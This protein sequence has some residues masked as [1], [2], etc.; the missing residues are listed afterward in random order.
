MNLYISLVNSNGKEFP[1][2]NCSFFK[3]EDS[4]I[5]KDLI[6]ISGGGDVV[7]YNVYSELG[8]F[9]KNIKLDSVRHV[10]GAY[11]QFAKESLDFSL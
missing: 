2:V 3:K 4:V 5:N 10:G 1:R 11:P 6:N 7:S 8:K 9:I